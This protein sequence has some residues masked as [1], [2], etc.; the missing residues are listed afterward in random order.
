MG[1][2]SIQSGGE[3]LLDA[4]RA[5]NPPQS[6]S[7]KLANGG[8]KCCCHG[9]ADQEPVEQQ[10]L[11]DNVEAKPPRRGL[12]SHLACARLRCR[13][14]I[15][16]VQ[17]ALAVGTEAVRC[18]RAMLGQRRFQAEPCVLETD[19]AA[20][21]TKHYK[22]LQVRDPAG[23]SN[24]PGRDGNSQQNDD[25]GLEQCLCHAVRRSGGAEEKVG[26]IEQLVHPDEGS[27]QQEPDGLRDDCDLG[28]GEASAGSR[29]P[30]RPGFDDSIMQTHDAVRIAP[31]RP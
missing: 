20:P 1:K 16:G 2:T 8:A 9:R 4:P 28:T 14:R 19:P 15:A 26:Q 13:C 25:G 12:R 6:K 18:P 22:R 24:R 3:K 5:S 17:L 29:S 7:C 10:D 11:K 30:L 21:C 31:G 23:R 27:K